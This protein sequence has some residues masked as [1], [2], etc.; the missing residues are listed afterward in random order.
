VP[1]LPAP[2]IVVH[3]QTKVLDMI[4]SALRSAGY[5]AAG[6]NDPVTALD[7]IET[8]SR[9]KVLVTRIDLGTGKLNGIALARMLHHNARRDI[10]VIFVGRDAN[11]Q[12]VDSDAGEFLPHP[13]DPSVLLDA[14]RRKLAE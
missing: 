7:A 14:V 12:F 1:T 10:K 9:V 13:I 5:E 8:D 2:I 3:Q 6:F 4:L 11:R